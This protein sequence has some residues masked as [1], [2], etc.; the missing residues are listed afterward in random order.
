MT[1]RAVLAG[2][3]L[4]RK[5]HIEFCAVLEMAIGTTCQ[6]HNLIAFDT[7]CSGIDRIGADRGQ[8]FKIKGDNLAVTLAGQA[9]GGFVFAR[10]NIG[11]EGFSTVGL[12]LHRTA[13][14]HR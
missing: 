4:V 14:H 5:D 8:I 3:V 10:V 6:I 13:K 7:A 9:N 1:H 12:K 11:D 2:N